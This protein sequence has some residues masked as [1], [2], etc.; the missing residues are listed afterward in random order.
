VVTSSLLSFFGG[1][2]AGETARRSSVPFPGT[3]ASLFLVI[4]V[5][6]FVGEVGN[7]VL[8]V[9]EFPVLDL[10]EV[11]FI[12]SAGGCIVCCLVPAFLGISKESLFSGGSAMRCRIPFSSS[13]DKMVPK[14]NTDPGQRAILHWEVTA[15]ELAWINNTPPTWRASCR[16]LELDHTPGVTLAVLLGRTVMLTVTQWFV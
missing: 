1:E 14:Q 3:L 13:T 12:W 9:S 16:C 6:S 2:G 10:Q 15:I 8:W 7:E 4:C 5:H 11:V